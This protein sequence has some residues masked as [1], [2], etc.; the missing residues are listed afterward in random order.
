MP[1]RTN[2]HADTLCSPRGDDP[3]ATPRGSADSGGDDPPEP[4]RG[5]ADSG[6]DD[7]P[8]PPRSLSAN[9]HQRYCPVLA[10]VSM[11]RP[12]SVPVLPDTRVLM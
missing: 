3:E 12:A 4:P 5:S 8:G 1:D 2:R 9:G 7:P 10:T 6:G 11:D